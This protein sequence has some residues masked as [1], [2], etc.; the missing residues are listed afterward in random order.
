MRLDGA[1]AMSAAHERKARIL[2]VDDHPIVREGLRLR[3][4]SQRDMEVCGEAED[5][6]EALTLVRDTRPNLVLIDISLAHSSGLDLIGQ[7]GARVPGVRMLALSAYD[8]SLYAERALKAGAH[9]Y[10][11]KSQ[12]QGKILDALREVLGGGCYLSPLLNRQLIG[13]A[14]GS[15]NPGTSSM[16]GELTNRELQV[17]ELIGRGRNTKAIGLELHLSPHTIDRHREKIKAKLGL[18][19]ALEL[20]RAALQWALS[21]DRGG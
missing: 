10:I 21:P 4:S 3:I 5:V 20:Q 19:N 1:P 9:G 15:R 14:L 18:D 6:K 11:G 13:R 17:F 12:A 2:I 16:V 7:L 8:D